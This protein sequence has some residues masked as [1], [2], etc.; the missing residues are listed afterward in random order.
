MAI[1]KKNATKVMKL[2]LLFLILGVFLPRVTQA[3]SKLSGKCCG[4]GGCCRDDETCCLA[5]SPGWVCCPSNYVCCS[6]SPDGCCPSNFT[7]CCHDYC[8]PAGATCCP[9]GSGYCTTGIES[10]TKSSEMFHSIRKRDTTTSATVAKY[11]DSVP[12]SSSLPGPCNTYH[13]EKK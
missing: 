4:L 12:V 10:K 9:V 11:V 1:L 13:A 5:Q 6:S 3:W 8:C 7:V 2:L